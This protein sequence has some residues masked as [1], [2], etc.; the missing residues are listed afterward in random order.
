MPM[1]TNMQITF[2]LHDLDMCFPLHFESLS[3]FCFHFVGLN[4]I[5][6]LFAKEC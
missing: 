4:L 2:F 1:Y 3:L 5:V 6:K